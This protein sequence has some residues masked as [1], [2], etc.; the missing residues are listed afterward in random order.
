MAAQ[1]AGKTHTTRVEA[2]EPPVEVFEKLAVPLADLCAG[3]MP[4]TVEEAGAP[5]ADLWVDK[6]QTTVVAGAPSVKV[7]KKL[8]APL[9]VLWDPG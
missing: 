8:A 3:K 9:V 1:D 7:C 6:T 5:L 4:P 2:G